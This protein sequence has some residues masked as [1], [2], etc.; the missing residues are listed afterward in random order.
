ML[1]QQILKTKANTDVFTIAPGLAVSDAAAKLSENRIG[2][3][4]VA[5]ESGHVVGVLSERDIVRTLGQRGAGCLNDKVDEMM[6]TDLVCATRQD[7]G[8]SVLQRMTDGRFRHMPVLEDGKLIGVITLGDV[9]K[10]RLAEL[11]ME[12]ESMQGMIMGR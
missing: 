8:E 10:A 12:N 3:L 7:T 2:A 11:A 5:D 6:T 4:I 9:V 1:V